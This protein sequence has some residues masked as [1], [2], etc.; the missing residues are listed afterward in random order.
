MAGGSPL[1]SCALAELVPSVEHHAAAEGEECGGL[2][3]SCGQVAL[4]RAVQVS[5]VVPVYLLADTPGTRKPKSPAADCS[6]PLSLAMVDPDSALSRLVT[7]RP[8]PSHCAQ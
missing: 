2:E 7:S 6:P 4:R 5:K 1:F 3:A 8:Y